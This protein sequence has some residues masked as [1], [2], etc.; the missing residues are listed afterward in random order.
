MKKFSEIGALSPE[1]FKRTTGIS[2]E[3]FQ[4]LSNRLRTR[5]DAEKKKNPMKKRGKKGTFPLEDKLLLT[6]YYLRH[7]ATFE[8]LGQLFRVSESYANKIYNRFS[9]ILVKILHVG[10]RENLMSEDLNAVI[11]DVSE[12]PVERPKKGQK[13]FYSGKKNGIRSRRNLS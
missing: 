13:A 1:E 7:Y 8:I 10:A 12:Q 3:N 5:L 4:Y 2:R 11:I 6:L 9:G